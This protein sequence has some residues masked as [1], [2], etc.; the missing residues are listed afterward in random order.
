MNTLKKLFSLCLAL[1]LLLSLAVPVSANTTT[2][3]KYTITINGIGAGHVYKAYQ[4]FAGSSSAS[5]EG[6]ETNASLQNFIARTL[7]RA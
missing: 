5:A 6:G 1:T 4:I 3:T 7:F 2:E